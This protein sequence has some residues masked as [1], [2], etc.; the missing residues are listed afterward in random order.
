MLNSGF[1][2]V[3]LTL[4]NSWTL[5][6]IISG[7]DHITNS[8]NIDF[9]KIPSGAFMMGCKQTFEHCEKN[10]EPR[11]RVVIGSFYMSVFEITQAQW[12]A[13]MG[14]NPSKFKGR[15]NPVEHVSW[16]D[17]QIFIRRLNNIEDRVYRL[18][19][20]AEWEYAAR[21]GASTNYF[22]GDDEEQ[23]G[24]YAWFNESL[25]FGKTHPVGK[26]EPNAFGLYDMFGNV[27]EWTCSDYA[28]YTTKKKTRCSSTAKGR[29]VLR[30]GS[31]YSGAAA[32]RSATRFNLEGTY[33]NGNIGFR[34]VL[35]P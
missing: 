10:E 23:L 19:T 22:F 14:D 34:L 21:A 5:G 12:V 15:T 18:P 28:L 9:V 35:L 7:E 13:V 3:A 26:L 27:L 30:G 1:L 6:N 29:K 32:L 33:S 20:E 11:Q 2:V 16:Q 25:S 24:R 17:I 8:I 4:I 31:L